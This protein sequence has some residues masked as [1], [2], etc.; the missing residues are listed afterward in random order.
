MVVGSG[1]GDW[2][3]RWLWRVVEV[4][5]VGCGWN[6]GGCGGGCWVGII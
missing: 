4:V 5:S 1:G 6:V 2:L 3:R